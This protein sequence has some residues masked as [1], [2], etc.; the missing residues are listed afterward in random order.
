MSDRNVGFI[1]SF[2]GLALISFLVVFLWLH[3]WLIY[4]SP[5]LLLPVAGFFAYKNP[6]K[7]KAILT[8]ID[9]YDYKPFLREFGPVTAPI[10]I[11]GSVAGFVYNTETFH[12]IT[13]ALL[14]VRG[15]PSYP[16]QI[17]SLIL[18]T[19]S[20]IVYA[21]YL[22]FRDPLKIRKPKNDY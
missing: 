20:I 8:R 14:R 4:Y 9:N 6:A 16:R 10:L 1:A 17:F 12:Y 7:I 11:L 18:F 21:E 19:I 13:Y 3:A 5:V 15:T 22:R 2:F